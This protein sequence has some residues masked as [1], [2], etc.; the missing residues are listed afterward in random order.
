[1]VSFLWFSTQTSHE[2]S[3]MRASCPA[4]VVLLDLIILTTFGE[5]YKLCNSSCDFLQL[6]VASSALNP[7]VVFSCAHIRGGLIS[8]WLYKENNKLRD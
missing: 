1:V 5:E 8:L 4:H 6:P 7:C 2:F 3:T